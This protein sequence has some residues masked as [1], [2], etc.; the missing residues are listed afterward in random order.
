MLEE[1]GRQGVNGLLKKLLRFLGSHIK[2]IGKS[3][4]QK[5][6]NNISETGK[7]S[8]KSL[9]KKGRDLSFSSEIKNTDQM[10]AICVACKKQGLAFAVQKTDK[11][12]RLIYQ[13]KDSVLVSDNIKKILK[14]QSEAKCSIVDIL[15]SMDKIKEMQ[16]S[17]ITPIK[18]REVE[19]R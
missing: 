3:I 16:V 14:K 9:V 17:R 12:Y 8:V 4:E 13:G 19:V 18:H 6:I 1:Q 2:N 15:K 7:K 5:A 10:K 11:G